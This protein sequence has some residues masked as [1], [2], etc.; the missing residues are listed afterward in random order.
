MGAFPRSTWRGSAARAGKADGEG[1][2]TA[3]SMEEGPSLPPSG[4]QPVQCHGHSCYRVLL[5]HGHE[6]DAE[7]QRRP[8]PNVTFRK[9][10]IGARKVGKRDDSTHPT[11][12]RLPWGRRYWGQGWN[13]VTQRGSRLSFAGSFEE[14]EHPPPHPTC[15]EKFRMTPF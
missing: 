7:Q 3:A 4:S 1:H 9:I 14:A 10:R 15:Q 6:L 2:L 11:A 13:N 5:R 8:T 12:A